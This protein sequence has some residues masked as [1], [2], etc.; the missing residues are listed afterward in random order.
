M[1]WIILKF[2]QPIRDPDKIQEIK[3]KLKKKSLRNYMLFV[4]GIN[5]GLRVSD[6]LKLKVKDVKDTDHIN[7]T[8]MKTGKQKKILIAP[9][10]KKEL[11][12]YI[13]NM[14]ESDFLIPSREGENKPIARNTA[15]LIL[16]NT[17]LECG[18]KEIGTHTMRKTFGYWFYKQYKDLA[19]LMDIF[20][21]SAERITLIY[22][23]INQD[24]KDK[25]MKN[26]VI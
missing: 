23:G 25:K 7:I 20:N 17:A 16:K 12:I 8:E 1:R 19:T 4:L 26:F 24:E 15:Y 13:E 21:H 3:E 9:N 22:I 10:L 18:L 6:I 5:T 14:K 11:K 2:V